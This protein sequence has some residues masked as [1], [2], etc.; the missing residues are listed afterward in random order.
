MYMENFIN[1]NLNEI[2]SIIHEN[3]YIGRCLN[4]KYNVRIVPSD[5]IDY[6]FVFVLKNENN[7]NCIN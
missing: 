4:I 6:K 5:V 3:W 7:Y 2:R 1:I